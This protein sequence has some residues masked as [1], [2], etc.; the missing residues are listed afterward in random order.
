MNA[1][2]LED[3]ITKVKCPDCGSELKYIPEGISKHGKPYNEFWV[4]TNAEDCGAKISRWRLF[5]Q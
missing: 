2:N 3:L 5:R 1:D 4:C